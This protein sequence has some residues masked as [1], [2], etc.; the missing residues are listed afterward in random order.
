[1]RVAPLGVLTLV[2][3]ALVSAGTTIPA[4]A[5]WAALQGWPSVETESPR[6]I[7]T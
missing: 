7:F 1:M 4:V 5:Q 2:S 3:A 6:G